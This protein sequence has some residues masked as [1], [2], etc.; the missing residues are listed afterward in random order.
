MNANERE[1]NVSEPARICC[2]GICLERLLELHF[3]CVHSPSIAAESLNPFLVWFVSFVVL[4]S[5]RLK[6]G[7]SFIRVSSVAKIL[8]TSAICHPC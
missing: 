8:F 4:L 7:L 1:K 5:F 3:I 2:I 6:A